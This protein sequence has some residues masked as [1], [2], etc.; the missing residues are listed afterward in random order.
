M[1]TT[2]QKGIFQ[3]KRINQGFPWK[4]KPAVILE[5]S[6]IERRMIKKPQCWGKARVGKAA[7]SKD[8]RKKRL[9]ESQMWNIFLP[10]FYIS[11][12]AEP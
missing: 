5:R 1:L 8:E 10:R 6:G 4:K 12:Q 9:N 7:G 11:S 3:T 2:H